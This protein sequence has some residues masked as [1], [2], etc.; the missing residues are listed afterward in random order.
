MIILL[1]IRSYSKFSL[2][3]LC[4]IKT[5]GFLK[6]F[7]R[8]QKVQQNIAKIFKVYNF[9]FLMKTWII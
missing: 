9:L 6:K 8:K 4:L 5:I 3:I 2:K 7:S 1:L